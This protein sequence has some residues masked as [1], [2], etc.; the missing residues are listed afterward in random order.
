VE[1]NQA[2]RTAERVAERRAVHQLLDHPIVFRDPLAFEV[3]QPEVASRIRA[4][5]R[6]YDRSPIATPLRAFLA[7]RSRFAEDSL[8][9]AIERGVSQYVII[10]AGFDTFAYRN[11]YPDIRVFEIDH[12]AT[13]AEK[14]QRLAAARIELPANVSLIPADLSVRSLDEALASAAFE[15]QKAAVFAWLGVIPYLELAAIETTFRYVASRP[16]GT[17][18]IFDYGIPRR[19]LNFIGRLVFDRM[20][21]RVAAIGEP[22]K[23]FFTPEDLHRLLTDVGFSAVED[24]GANEIN[25]RYFAGRSDRLRVGEAGRIARAVV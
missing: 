3:L 9:T 13:Q 16:A 19:S 24:L 22:W 11:P 10:G 20:A 21:N 8:R 7:V 5:P 6:D 1:R 14:K 25:A 17:E 18:I 4:A 12:P 15:S 23:T 2:S